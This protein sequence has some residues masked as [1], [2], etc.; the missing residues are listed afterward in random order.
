VALRL[1][2]RDFSHSPARAVEKSREKMV[3]IDSVTEVLN[4][5]MTPF[6][7]GCKFLLH[8]IIFLNSLI[9]SSGITNSK[10]IRIFLEKNKAGRYDLGLCC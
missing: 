7:S 9:A 4:L 8:R 5:M 3:I 6:G 1:S 10:S 2:S